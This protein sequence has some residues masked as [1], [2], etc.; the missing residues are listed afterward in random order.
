MYLAGYH[1]IYLAG[2]YIIGF[3]VDNMGAAAFCKV[4]QMIKAV[5]MRKMQ[6]VVLFEVTGKAVSQQIMLLVAAQGTYVIYRVTA[7]HTTKVA[8][9]CHR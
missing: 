9:I 6:L 8:V 7:N 4:Y 2:F 1:K 5:L 3:K